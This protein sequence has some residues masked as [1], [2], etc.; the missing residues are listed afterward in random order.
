MSCAGRR[1]I[2]LF[3]SWR[4]PKR[5]TAREHKQREQGDGSYRGLRHGSLLSMCF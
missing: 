4:L 2:C 5:P 1:K 3:F